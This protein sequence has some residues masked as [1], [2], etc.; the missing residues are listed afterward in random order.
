MSM[1]LRDFYDRRRWNRICDR[2]LIFTL[3]LLYIPAVGLYAPTP[4]EWVMWVITPVPALAMA[5]AICYVV[6]LCIR[7]VLNWLKGY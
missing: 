6:F 5:T 7:D 4:A 3:A 1:D 2:W